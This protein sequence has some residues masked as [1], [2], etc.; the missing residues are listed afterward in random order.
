MQLLKTLGWLTFTAFFGMLTYVLYQEVDSGEPQ[1]KYSVVLTIV[2]ENGPTVIY[3]PDDLYETEADCLV[4]EG[5]WHTIVAGLESL[6]APLGSRPKEV[7]LSLA[8]SRSIR[9]QHLASRP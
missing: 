5:H 9:F 4:S 6:K 7:L 1:K 8:F 2:R 3:R